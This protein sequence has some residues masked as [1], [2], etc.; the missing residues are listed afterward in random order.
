MGVCVLISIF[1]TYY[2]AKVKIVLDDSWE[3]NVTKSCFASD[4]SKIQ[5]QDAIVPV[6]ILLVL[7]LTLLSAN[8]FANDSKIIYGTQK[9]VL[10]A[11]V[12]A[13]ASI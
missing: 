6:N 2:S 3:A 11:I 12:C 7:M 9:H 8:Y 1:F 5:Q 10:I 13:G 4:W